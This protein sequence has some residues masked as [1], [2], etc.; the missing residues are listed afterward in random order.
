MKRRVNKKIFFLIW[1]TISQLNQTLDHTLDEHPSHAATI[2]KRQRLCGFQ[3]A[4]GFLR[5][6]PWMS[7]AASQIVGA[8]CYL[9]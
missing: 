5:I 2:V 4:R 1:P 7:D 9:F 3:R 6:E 8:R